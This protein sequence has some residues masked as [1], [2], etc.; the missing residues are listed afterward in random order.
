MVGKIPGVT[1]EY[2]GGRKSITGPCIGSGGGKCQASIYI[3]EFLV[4]ND[5][6]E[7]I[8]IEDVAYI[9]YYE[10]TPWLQGFPNSISIYLKKGDDW[11]EGIKDLPSKLSQIK[12]AG[13]SPVK[14]FYSPDYSVPNDKQFNADLRTTLLWQPYVLTNKENKKVTISFYNNDITTK[15]KIVIEGINEDGK[16]IHIEKIME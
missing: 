10:K 6:L 12:I 9:K 11:K 7:T 16:L 3:N 1:V 13:Y 14:E 5:Y 8:N 2:K 15:F 4:D